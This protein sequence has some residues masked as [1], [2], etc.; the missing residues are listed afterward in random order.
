MAKSMKVHV[1]KV[2]KRVARLATGVTVRRRSKMTAAARKILKVAVSGAVYVATAG[3]I[4]AT[5]IGGV[6]LLPKQV[7]K[8]AIK[9]VEQIAARASDEVSA[10]VHALGI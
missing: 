6:A 9:N 4:V 2:T 5:A 7:R 1:R 3:L 10:K 8:R